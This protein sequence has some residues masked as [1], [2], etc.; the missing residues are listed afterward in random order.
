M[1][2]AG[3]YIYVV[4]IAVRK[5]GLMS[6]VIHGCDTTGAHVGDWQ[7]VLKAASNARAADKSANRNKTYLKVAHI[8][9][10]DA[11]KMHP[12]VCATV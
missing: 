12:E 3:Q 11:A 5:I 10:V 8:A 7:A 2:C 4:C 9:V 1:H 6:I